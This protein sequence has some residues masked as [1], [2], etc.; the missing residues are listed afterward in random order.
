MAKFVFHTKISGEVNNQLLNSEFDDPTHKRW[1]V[2]LLVDFHNLTINKER[3]NKLLQ[4]AL[5]TT[6]VIECAYESAKLGG[7]MLELPYPSK[8]FL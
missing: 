8:E 2:D 7:K 3:Q 5:L 4:E 1:F 6:I